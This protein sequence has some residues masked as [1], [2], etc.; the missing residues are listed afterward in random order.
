MAPN[1]LFIVSDFPPAFGGG[2]SRY[3]YSLCEY[4]RGMMAVLTCH[5][6]SAPHFDEKQEFLTFRARVPLARSLISRLIQTILFNIRGVILARQLRLTTLIF[7]HWYLAIL[8]PIVRYLF[9]LS[10][11]VILYGGESERLQKELLIKRVAFFALDRAN[12][13]VVISEHTRQEYL[14]CGGNNRRIVKV[15]PGVDIVRFTPQVNCQ[16]IIKRHTLLGK[17]VLLT[18]S[19]LV[20]RKGHEVVIRAMPKI[21]EACPETVYL[22]VGAGPMDSALKTLASEQGVADKVI[23]VGTVPESE[24]AAYYNACQVFIMPSRHFEGREGV[25]G[26]GIVYLEANACGK[27]VIGGRS[28]GI[29]EAI[30]DGVSGLVIDPEDSQAVADSAIKLL[31]D[32]RLS[33]ELGRK[34]R[35][36]VEREFAWEYQWKQLELILEGK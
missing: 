12:A 19:R 20:E 15:N 23:F 11:Y 7:G 2:I 22:I 25:E 26:F 6:N 8:A 17:Q 35:Y 14:R 36:R 18:V 4:S 31:T 1:A 10:F 5:T 13:V 27:P 3:C 24:L 29:I 32:R 16:Q 30:D 21:V 33:E 34:G 28:G 9:G